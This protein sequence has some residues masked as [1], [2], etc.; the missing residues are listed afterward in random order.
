[1]TE[2][3]QHARIAQTLGFS[4]LLPMLGVLVAIALRPEFA[5]SLRL[6]GLLYV[7][8]IFSF[9]GGI[10]WGIAIQ[11]HPRNAATGRFLT[12]LIVGVMPA[13]ATV[14]ALVTT[15]LYGCLLLVSGL[16]LLL[17]FEWRQGP[18]RHLPSWY[19]P[20]RCNLTLLLSGTLI[21]VFWLSR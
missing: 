20:L 9:L 19:F 16:W 21:A 18:Q 2:P 7:G 3:T 15:H 6:F 1:M 10:Q 14:L 5:D 12:Q 4:G 11:D 17:A 8:A 13:L